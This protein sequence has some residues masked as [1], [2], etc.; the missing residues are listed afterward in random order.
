[1][2]YDYLVVGAGLYGATFAR[3][4]KDAGKKCLVIDRRE[5]LAGNCF[6]ERKEGILVNAYGGH[7][8]HTNSRAIWTFVSRFAKFSDYEHR[9]KVDYRGER[10]SF[11]INLKTFAE[12]GWGDTVEEAKARLERE[13]VPHPRPNYFS[14]YV[15]D[16]VGPEL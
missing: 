1:M 9:V 3:A 6:D 5:H 11:P 7:I 16:Q 4:A 14:E 15:L 12:L 8:F 2:R 13:R 10:Y